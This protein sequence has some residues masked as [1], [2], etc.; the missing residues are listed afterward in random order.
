MVYTKLFQASLTILL[1]VGFYIYLYN[2]IKNE[3]I[4]AFIQEKFRLWQSRN[5]DLRALILDEVKRSESMD[6]C[7][8][9]WP[10]DQRGQFKLRV[11]LKRLAAL[12]ET[13]QTSVHAKYRLNPAQCCIEFTVEE[14][15][16]Y[17]T[18]RPCLAKKKFHNLFSRKRKIRYNY[19]LIHRSSSIYESDDLFLVMKMLVRSLIQEVGAEILF[20]QDV[21]APPAD[22]AAARPLPAGGNGG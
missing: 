13:F 8:L 3:K 4:D 20:S 17:I 16:Y 11:F 9:C 1:V 12:T 6:S 15:N 19:N 14:V 2:T 22:S 18:I 7:A 10:E 5:F 21:L